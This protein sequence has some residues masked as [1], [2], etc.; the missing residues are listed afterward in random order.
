M[1]PVTAENI[2]R[3]ELIGLN[4]R[5]SGG[6]NKSQK[7]IKGSIV[8]ETRNTLTLSNGKKEKTVSKGEASFI[9]NLGGTLVEVKGKTLIGRPE[10]RVK[11]KS[12]RDW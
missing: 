12:K 11:K 9:F 7:K 3:H 8:A 1:T 5:V 6:N 4:A 2:N 10:D